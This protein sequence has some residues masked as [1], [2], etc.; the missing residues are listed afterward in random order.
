MSAGH[1]QTKGKGHGISGGEK[2]K[3]VVWLAVFVGGHL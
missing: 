3:V 2:L 1:A